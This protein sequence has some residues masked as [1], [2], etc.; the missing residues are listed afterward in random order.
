MLNVAGFS[1]QPKGFD[2]LTGQ[3]KGVGFEL[4]TGFLGDDL[5]KAVF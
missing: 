1:L 3:I 2:D 5:I 4:V